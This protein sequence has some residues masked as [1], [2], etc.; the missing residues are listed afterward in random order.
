[1]KLLSLD[2]WSRRFASHFFHPNLESSFHIH[3]KILTVNLECRS[4]FCEIRRV[5]IYVVLFDIRFECGVYYKSFSN[6][7]E[8]LTHYLQTD[9]SSYDLVIS[10][11]TM[12][13]INDFQLY[14][15]LKAI[16]KDVKVL[17]ATCLKKL[18]RF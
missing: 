4:W 3:L 16:N 6:S 13:E 14:H 2:W 5:D 10:D 1:L 8:A 11:I 9:P 7:R 17:F 12:P 18:R 15:K